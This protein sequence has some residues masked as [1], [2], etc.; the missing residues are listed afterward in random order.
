MPQTRGTTTGNK[1][2]EAYQSPNQ[3]RECVLCIQ[4]MYNP[5]NQ[6]HRGKSSIACSGFL[7]INVSKLLLRSLAFWVTY[8]LYA[9]ILY[10]Y[11][12]FVFI[13]IIYNIKIYV[14]KNLKTMFV[15][16]FEKFSKMSKWYFDAISMPLMSLLVGAFRNIYGPQNIAR[17]TEAL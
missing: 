17:T 8:H 1:L 10:A 12:S 5:L 6:R 11:A 14:Y 13:Y 2:W 7:V 16:H 15:W 4:K 3:T 9:F